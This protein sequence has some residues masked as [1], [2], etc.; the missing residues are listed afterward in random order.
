MTSLLY[1]S[2][3][4]YHAI[5]KLIYGKDFNNRYKEIAKIIGKNKK[6]LDLG[7]GT[8]ELKKHLDES[9]TYEGWDLNQKFIKAG[10]EKGLNVKLKNIFNF[11]KYPESDVIVISDLLH[12]VIP[13][14]MELIRK[15]KKNTKKLVI[16][17]PF[18]T[19]NRDSRIMRWL[20]KLWDSTLGDND[21]I[22]SFEQRSKWFRTKE[23]VHEFFKSL[24][25]E[26]IKEVGPEYLVVL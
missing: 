23:E 11:K 14:H 5:I 24:N 15:A 12:H 3:R 2:P 8:G 13:R 6:V 22:N 20:S 21:G 17:E 26:L 1:K 16:M 4:L 10:K 25:P 7:C 19:I 9:C 18:V